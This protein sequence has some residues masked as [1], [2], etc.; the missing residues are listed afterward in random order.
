MEQMSDPIQKPSHYTQYKI[1]P[2]DVIEAWGANFHIG[3]VIKYLCRHDH[4]GTPLQDLKKA[5]WYLAREIA[6]RERE[7]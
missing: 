2:I 5:Q 7:V 3:N 6:R 1:E 4:K